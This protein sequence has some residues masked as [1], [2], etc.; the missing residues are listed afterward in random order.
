MAGRGAILAPLPG[1]MFFLLSGDPGTGSL[2]G[3]EGSLPDMGRVGGELKLLE[4][5]YSMDPLEE[6]LG[7]ETYER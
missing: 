6:L 7:S 2:S 3:Q 5:R 1:P 4:E